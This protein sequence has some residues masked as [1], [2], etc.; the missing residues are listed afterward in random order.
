MRL[1]WTS[2]ASGDLDRIEQHIAQDDPLVAMDVVLKVIEKLELILPSYPAAG[3]LGRVEGTRE[4]VLNGL[5]FVVVYREFPG[6]VQ[7]LRVLND[8][9]QWPSMERNQT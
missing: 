8:A 9:Q 2:L 1:R 3:R 5:P 4:L 6:E 7:I